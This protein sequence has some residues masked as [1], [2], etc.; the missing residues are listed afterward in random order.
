MNL[1]Y[2]NVGIIVTDF[3]RDIDGEEKPRRGRKRIINRR[4]KRRARR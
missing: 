3:D 4:R 1:G 2:F